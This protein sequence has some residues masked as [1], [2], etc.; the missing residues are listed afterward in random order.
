MQH[1]PLT[2]R[3][4]RLGR[5]VLRPTP[6]GV[7]AELRGNLEGLLLLIGQQALVGT[8]GSGA[9]FRQFSHASG[10]CASPKRPRTGTAPR[11]VAPS[12]PYSTGAPESP[13]PAPGSGD[14]A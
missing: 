14:H 13:R 10:K 8:T 11:E 9:R 5:I 2:Y 4:R 6:A 3:T 1:L 7:A 12:C